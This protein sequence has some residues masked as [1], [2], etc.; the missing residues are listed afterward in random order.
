M[1]IRLKNLFYVQWMNRYPA[2]GIRQDQWVFSSTGNRHFDSNARYLFIYV[3]ENLPEIT[4][5][6]VMNDPGKRERLQKAYP[7]A[8]IVD[9]DTRAGIRTVLESGVWFTSAGL[10]VYG[11]GLSR[12]RLVVNLWHGV[13]LK[14]ITLV[15]H[16]KDLFYR[17]YFPLVF[18][19]NYSWVATTSSHLVPLMQASFGVKKEQV[20]VL[21]Q[22]RNDGLFGTRKAAEVLG[23]LYEERMLPEFDKAVLYAPTHRD[24]EEVRLF[25]FRDYDGEELA[26]FLER[27]KILLCIRMHSFTGAAGDLGQTPCGSGDE[28]LPDSPWILWLGEDRAEDVMEVLDVFNLLITD[29]SSIYIDFLLTQKPMLFLPYDKKEY[30]QGRGL[31]LPYRRVTPGP[32]PDTFGD[33]CS[34]MK[35]LLAGDDPY[36]ERRQKANRYF[37]EVNGPCCGQICAQV[38]E[39][40]KDTEL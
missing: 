15:E 7:R 29:Y 18:S 13:P 34:Q 37:N 4:P 38:Q 36:R 26:R 22:P 30:L 27:E 20:K 19:R 3:Y 31:N 8:K 11:L 5:V 33:F 17:M 14:K 40:L 21:G 2:L 25:P 1:D 6:Y 9:T 10:P 16:K 32:K 24:G 28:R 12:G 35:S 39:Y 23:G